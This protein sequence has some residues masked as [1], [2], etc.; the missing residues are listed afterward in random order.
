VSAGYDT[1]RVTTADNV[2]INFRVAGLATRFTAAF[3]DGLLLLVLL[4][5]AIVLIGAIV[6]ALGG[7]ATGNYAAEILSLA[8]LLLAACLVLIAILSFTIAQ[9]VSGGRT[10]GKAAMGLRV[11]RVDGG[12]ANLGA[13]FLRSAAYIPD[14]LLAVGPILMFFHPQSRRLGDLLAGTVVVRERPPLTLQAATAPSPVYLR[15]GDP[16]PGID[17]LAN[18]GERELDAVRTFLSRPGLLPAQRAELAGRIASRLLERMDLPF[19]A[20]ERMWPP[21]LFLERLYLQLVARLRPGGA[22]AAA[23]SPYGEIAGRPPWAP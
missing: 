22:G 7:N 9:A 1:Q 16:G 17:G 10:P 21:E 23:T 18:L 14:L 4:F 8:G 12:T 20:P 5:V 13:Y 6:D 11:I 15:S 19:G 2:G 3:L